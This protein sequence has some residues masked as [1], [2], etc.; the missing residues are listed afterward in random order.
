MPVTIVTTSMHMVMTAFA[1][2]LMQ[3]W[4]ASWPWYLTRASGLLAAILLFLLIGS[5]VGLI[6]GYTFR[7]LEPVP[8]WTVH[9]AISIAFTISASVHVLSLLF[10][11]YVGFNFVQLFVPFLSKYTPVT[12]FGMHVG[13]LWVALGIFA[14][15]CVAG[16][17]FTS[18]LWINK[19]PGTWRVT[20]YLTYAVVIFTFFHA[21]GLGTD[22][23]HG[24]GRV[25]WLTGGL[26]VV[27]AIMSRL[28]LTHIKR[29]KVRP[30]A[31]GQP[32]V[33]P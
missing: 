24:V 6:T 18:L 30:A 2:Q 7:F 14:V 10:D 19:K 13:S 1:S 11:K 22:V 26:L 31:G 33:H 3:R 12:L 21:L 17:M 25:L 8:A 4:D 23:K 15:Y 16:I 9:R 5:G 29:A 32:K 27:V 20:H 28:R